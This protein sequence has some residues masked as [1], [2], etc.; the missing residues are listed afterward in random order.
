V[1]VYKPK[2]KPHFH[3]DFQFRGK[4]YHGS[5]GCTSRR[6]AEAFERRER[7][8]AALPVQ[9]RPEITLD[10][11]ASLYQDHA[12]TL[13]SWPTIRYMLDAL[14]DGIGSKRLLSEITQ[15]D[16]QIYFARRRDE[17]SNAS[18]NREIEN[19]RSLWRRA[20]DARFEVGEM[21]T[22]GTLMLKV[23]KKPPRELD[24][25]EEE[26]LFAELR[27]D[28][29]DA[30]DFLLKSGWRRAEVLSLRWSDVKFP[31]RQAATRIK[32]GDTVMRPLTTTLIEIIARQPQAGPFVFTYV[33]QRTKPAFVDKRGRKHPARLAGERYPLTPTA[34]RRP[35]AH[36]KDEAGI[37]NF[38]IHDLRHTRGTRIVRATGSLAAAKE[39]LK[40]KRI[41]TTLRYAH[42]L[43]EDVRNALDASE[44]SR[45][46]PDQVISEKRKA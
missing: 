28:L 3:F 45:H 26:G 46:S 13:P 15:R 17:R 36:A 22:W 20:K 32:G 21:P 6:A 5:T 14:V 38:R 37:S 18:V 11:A 10:E 23:P 1:S 33:A 40:H 2:G 24:L 41:E 16:L 30:V 8:Q 12:E 7:Q 19:A 31:T 42:V 35:F 4:R 9:A 27:E 43:D 34:L 25:K 29:A 39:A 44:Q